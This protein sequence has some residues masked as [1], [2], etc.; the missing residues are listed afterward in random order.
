MDGGTEEDSAKLVHR[1]G[2]EPPLH[3]TSAGH[4]DGGLSGTLGHA[5]GWGRGCSGT[6]G[7][8]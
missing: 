1:W 8:P 2:P 3:E 7:E 4:A 6:P 5:G